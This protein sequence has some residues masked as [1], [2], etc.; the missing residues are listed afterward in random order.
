MATAR[1]IAGLGAGVPWGAVAAG[2]VSSDKLEEAVARDA[3]PDD[4]ERPPPP[5]AVDLDWRSVVTFLAAFV[6]LVA[7]TGMFRG[8]TRTIT[9]IVL[10]SLL[11]LALDPLVTKLKRRCGGHRGIAVAVVLIGFIALISAVGALFGPA[12]VDEAA[13]L[14]SDLPEVVEDL[15]RLPL[16]GPALRD[17]DLDTRVQAFL[18]DLPGR[19]A[20]DTS[21]LE[22]AARSILGGALAA[23]ATLLVALTLMLDG[24][25]LLAQAR[26]L[27]PA[28]QRPRADRIGSLGYRVVAQYFAGSLLVAGIAGLSV[29]V[30]GLVLGVPLAPLAGLWVTMTNLVPQ[31]GGA[32]GGVPFVLL[33]FTAGAFVGLGCL[34]FFLCYLQF[35][36]NILSPLVVGKSVDLS[37]PATMTAALIGV[38]AAGVVGALVAVP[39]LGAAKAVYLELR[40]GTRDE[41]VGGDP[42]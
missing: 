15:G 27:V 7:L 38:S 16:V 23:V 4:P 10:G 6:V 30:V 3:E 24:E 41:V 34:V 12:A 21:P 14:G 17:A 28:R 19:L 35:E 22:Q 39:L 40:P 32:A 29:T 31:I 26:R 37:P 5:V 33:G 8:A 42:D 2:S 13:D 1:S 20:G 11:A 9:W 36:N 18:D 25:R